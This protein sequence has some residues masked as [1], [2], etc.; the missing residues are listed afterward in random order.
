MYISTS[1]ILVLSLYCHGLGWVTISRNDCDRL[2]VLPHSN[3]Q[4]L[5]CRILPD[6]KVSSFTQ[7]SLDV[8]FQVCRKSLSVLAEC[9]TSINS[10]S[11]QVKEQLDAGK[12]IVTV[13]M[14]VAVE[15]KR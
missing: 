2:V 5:L 7:S 12:E 15:I 14:M 10:F 9:T 8:L 4:V 11:E 1:A 13:D 3:C 6:F